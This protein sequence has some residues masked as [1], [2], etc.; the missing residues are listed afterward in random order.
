MTILRTKYRTKCISTKVTD[1]EYATLEY[2]A[3]GETLSAW[4]RG[5][6]LSAARSHPP[7]LVLVAEFLALRT[8][9]LNLLF[10]VAA[11][12]PPTAEAMHRLIDRADQE[13]LRKAQERLS[14]G[15]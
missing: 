10:A 5:V 14:A 7:E 1:A 4:A 15:L 11:G 8:I 9:V 12:E 6:L 3:T 13:K 2:K